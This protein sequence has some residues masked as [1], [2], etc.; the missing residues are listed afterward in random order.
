MRTSRPRT[1]TLAES[2]DFLSMPEPNSG[3]RLWLGSVD[4]EGYG[5]LMHNY[6]II[7]A[8]RAAWEVAHGEVPPG[9][10]VCH[11]CDVPGCVEPRHLFVG[12][13]ADNNRDR[14]IKGRTARLCGEKSS[15]ALR[16]ARKVAALAALALTAACS[17]KPAIVAPD[18]GCIWTQHIDVTAQQVDGMK[19]DPGTWRPLAV[20]ITDHNANRLKRCS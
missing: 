2:L 1:L 11:K 4:M 7:K 20:Q 8:H 19:K 13:I 16:A 15:S 5:R 17:S 10:I 9:L 6:R 3:C 12:T 18:V 14:S